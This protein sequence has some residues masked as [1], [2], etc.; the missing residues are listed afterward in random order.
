MGMRSGENMPEDFVR[1]VR[2][3][4]WQVMIHGESYEPIVAEAAKKAIGAENVFQRIF[5]SHRPQA[6]AG[7]AGAALP[8]V[9]ALIITG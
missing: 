6:R 8:S 2:E 4:E 9:L 3:G 1:Y 7:F 5:I